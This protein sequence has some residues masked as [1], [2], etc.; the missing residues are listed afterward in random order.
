MNAM[1]A[2]QNLVAAPPAPP[3]ATK[4][5]ALRPRAT[6]GAVAVDP[7]VE[8]STIRVGQTSSFEYDVSATGENTGGGVLSE[9][10]FCIS[11]ELFGGVSVEMEVY[12]NGS[13]IDREAT[14]LSNA[15]ASR[16]PH[17]LTFQLQGTSP[18]T[19]TIR[20]EVYGA[21]TGNLLGEHQTAVTIEDPGDGNGGGG[22][23]GGA[24]PPPGNGGDGGSFLDQ[25]QQLGIIIAVILGLLL[26]GNISR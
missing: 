14:C 19:G 1:R 25:A 22:G 12:F 16:R 6:F 20:I 23:G 9:D 4:E 13:R 5:D 18:G 26:A 11:P 17:D 7:V 8:P 15:P 24:E 2:R 10:D 21:V 3:G